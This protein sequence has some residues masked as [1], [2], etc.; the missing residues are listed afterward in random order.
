MPGV[1]AGEGQGFVTGPTRL[2]HGQSGLPDDGLRGDRA[3]SG[4][5]LVAG[6]ILV[7]GLALGACAV[8]FGPGSDDGSDSSSQTPRERNQ[9]YLQEQ[10]RQYRQQQFDR[11]GPSDR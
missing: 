6:L 10:Q 4:R 1:D 8:P 3:G 9:L 7:L 2:G 5:R 11:V